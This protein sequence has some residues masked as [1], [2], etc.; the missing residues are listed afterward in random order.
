MT[1]VDRHLVGPG[2]TGVL[3]DGKSRW[4]VRADVFV[5]ANQLPAALP[6]AITAG[7]TAATDAVQAAASPPAPA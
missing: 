5:D 2:V 6:A 7:A 3:T 4:D 1:I